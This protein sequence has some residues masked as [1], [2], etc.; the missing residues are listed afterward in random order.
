M[1][2]RQEWGSHHFGL[3]SASRAKPQPAVVDQEHLE[4]DA[5][6]ALAH[7]EVATSEHSFEGDEPAPQALFEMRVFAVREMLLTDL[8]SQ[9]PPGRHAW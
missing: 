3:I 6:R 9:A 5:H 2:E 1:L 7:S 4:F 8:D